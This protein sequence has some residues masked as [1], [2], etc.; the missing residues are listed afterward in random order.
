MDPRF[1]NK[2]IR[3]E[4]YQL[5]TLED[6]ATRLSG[7]KCFSKLDANHGYWQ[8]PLDPESQLL[9]TFNSPFGRYCFRRMPFGVKSAQE[10]FQKRMNQNFGDLPGPGVET[11]IDDI[12]V[13]GSSNEEHNRR[14][15]AVLQRCLKI[16]LTLNREKCKFGVSEVTYLGH[17]INAEGISPDKKKIRA[18]SEMPPK[19]KK[20]VERLLGV[21]NYV[22]KFIPNMSAVTHPIRE[23]LRKDVQ[24]NWSWEQS[25][26]FQKV[27]KLISEAPVLAFFNVKKPVTVSCDASQYGLGAVLL[28]DCQPVA[29][30][31]RALTDTERR[32]AQIVKRSY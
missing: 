28:Q 2:A 17:T 3:R 25:D 9:T 24:F 27:K 19:D 1:L 26:A 31:S 10:I 11:D 7:A 14:L 22:G 29:Y 30:A 15:E 23:L 32:Y 13:W 18:I 20:G 4:H 21:I 8:I 16:G 5:P 6:I 12:L